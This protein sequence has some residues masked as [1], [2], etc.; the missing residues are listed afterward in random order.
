[1]KLRQFTVSE[2]LNP[3]PKAADVAHALLA[4]IDAA[5]AASQSNQEKPEF[6]RPDGNPIFPEDEEWWLTELEKRKTP[7]AHTDLASDSIADDN[8]TGN[9][10]E[11][12]LSSD[13]HDTESDESVSTDEG[14][15]LIPRARRRLS[16]YTVGASRENEQC[17]VLKS[18][19]AIL[20][21]APKRRL[22]KKTC[23]AGR[24]PT[25]E[26]HR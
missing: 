10:S 15:P 13:G 20:S 22:R 14:L 5:D 6:V 21:N 1:M 19:S 3:Q 26:E 8:L 2:I 24:C 25:I 7:E 18:S 16:D 9:P 11:A 23:V 12:G 17:T 4:W